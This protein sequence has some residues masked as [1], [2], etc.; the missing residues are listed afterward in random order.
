[1][2]YVAFNSFSVFRDHFE[3]IMT[4]REMAHDEPFLLLPNFFQLLIF[5]TLTFILRDFQQSCINI[6]KLSVAEYCN[7][8]KDKE[9][10][11]KTHT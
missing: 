8:G 6:F 10:A 9:L 11:E 5:N 4:K 2:F 1:M 3:N 7:K